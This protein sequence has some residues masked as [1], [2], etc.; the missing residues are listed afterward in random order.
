MEWKKKQQQKAAKVGQLCIGL[1][2]PIYSHAI[3]PPTA[4]QLVS[5]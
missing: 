4:F 3:D 5:K 2:I 1:V